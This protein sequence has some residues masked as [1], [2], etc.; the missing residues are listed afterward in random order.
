MVS[1]LQD[2]YVSLFAYFKNIFSGQESIF[3][4]FSNSL[5]GGMLSTIAYYLVS[6]FNFIILFFDLENLYKGILLIISIKIALSGLTMYIYLNSKNSNKLYSLMFSL[7]YSLM[8]YNIN[9]YFNIMWLDAVLI[10]PLILLGIDKIVNSKTSILF[11]LTLFMAVL[12]NYYMGYMIC[13]FSFFYIIGELYKKYDLKRDKKIIF[14]I[15]KRYF[16]TG[17]LACLLTSFLL[18]PSTIGLANS[19]KEPSH[20]FNS[21]NVLQSPLD[22]FA[23]TTLASHNYLNIINIKTVNIYIG[24][25]TLILLTFSF[26]NK[27]ITKKE[28]Y[29]N[30]FMIILFMASVMIE[31]LNKIWHG[32][33]SPIGFNYRFAFMFGLYFIVI[34]YKSL[35]NIN[36]VKLKYFITYFFVYVFLSLL[37]VLKN[38]KYISIYFIILSIIFTF[39][40]LLCLF[41]K[42]KEEKFIYLI[43]LLAFCEMNANAF[44]T[45]S[46]FE[47][48]RV[49]DYKE[50][51]VDMKKYIDKYE[52]NYRIEKFPKFNRNDSF[53]LN[54]KG[55]NQFLST[56]N[57]DTLEFLGKMGLFNDELIVTYD[58]WSTEILNSLMGVKYIFGYKNLEDYNEIENTNVKYSRVYENINSLSIGYMVSE[59]VLNY[60]NKIKKTS[61]EFQN[62]IMNLMLNKNNFY[63]NEV[64]VKKTSLDNYEIK[65]SDKKTYMYIK[66]NIEDLSLKKI[67]YKLNDKKN[68][69][70]Y[71]KNIL[72]LSLPE[73]INL[74][75]LN[76]NQTIK[77]DVKAYTYNQNLFDDNI[78]SLKDE[79]LNIK[80]MEKNQL[81]GNIN[82]LSKGIMFT[83]IPYEKGWNI[84]VDGKKIKY[85]K[86]FNSF[87]GLELERGN[88][89]I[90]FEYYPKGLNIGIIISFLDLIVIFIYFSYQLKKIDND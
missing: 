89:E 16:L 51:T 70:R 54:F 20:I 56:A 13:F 25:I 35:F 24:L 12:T 53:L 73:K 88:H 37:V 10:F 75:I 74:K 3:Y 40:F 77:S 71:N 36:E 85:K 34:A 1:D 61:F 64:E 81:K 69:F 23:R 26:I 32:F 33:A 39:L 72:K 28:K 60:E 66:T 50:Y 19:Y 62:Y 65:G 8:A 68:F 2:Q 86:I 18:I 9:F 38:Y 84:K 7:C 14:N 48:C 49:L 47:F 46:K 42:R 22:I 67:Y 76:K 55:I 30:L 17:L 57:K 82:V 83:S 31:P 78:I 90:T 80:Y 63:Y 21:F 52:G 4:S 58:D 79:Q 41:L 6:P 29:F 45:F 59:K 15:F 27:N 43:F 5:G 44:F 11:G 87:I